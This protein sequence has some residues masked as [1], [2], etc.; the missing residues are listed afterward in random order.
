MF[1]FAGLLKQGV[2][3]LNTAQSQSVKLPIQGPC[4]TSDKHFAGPLAAVPCHANAF[5]SAK[6]NAQ[7]IGGYFAREG[8]P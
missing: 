1:A 8:D 4:L 3:G 7:L 2:G 5:P 6:A